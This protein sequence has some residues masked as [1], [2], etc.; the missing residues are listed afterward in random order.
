MS[1][2]YRKG[3][4]GGYCYYWLPIVALAVFVIAAYATNGFGT[5]AV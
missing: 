1:P 3:P 4:G 2:V 5:G